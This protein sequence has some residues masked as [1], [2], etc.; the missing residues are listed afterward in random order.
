[1]ILRDQDASKKDPKLAL[2]SSAA[3]ISSIDQAESA[4]RVGFALSDV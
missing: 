4:H 3:A 1:V 2:Y